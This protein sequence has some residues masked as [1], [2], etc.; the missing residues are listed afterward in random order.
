[1]FTLKIEVKLMKNR[2]LKKEVVYAGYVAGFL[3]FVGFIYLIE[4]SISKNLFK[5]NDDDYDY[6]SKTIS[7]LPVN[8]SF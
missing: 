7:K 3:L 8:P 6:V 5:P 2:K 4:T 1:M